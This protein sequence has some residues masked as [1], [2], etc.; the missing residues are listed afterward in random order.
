MKKLLFAIFPVILI[1]CSKEKD[2]DP[3]IKTFEN[4]LGKYMVCD[5]VKT[6]T[7]GFTTKQ[8][9]GKGKGS[10]IIIGR[11]GMFTVVSNP[12]VTYKFNFVPG[13]LY[14]WLDNYDEN[15]FYQVNSLEGSKMVLQNQEGNSTKVRF[16]TA[17]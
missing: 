2:T 3:Q 4:L 13:K 16:Y 8:V 1:S 15:Q 10:D 12:E 9:L 5:S 11:Y 6:T 7:N 14:Y 17:E